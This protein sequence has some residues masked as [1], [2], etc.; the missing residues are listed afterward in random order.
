MF[1]CWVCGCS[2]MSVE[3]LDLK[4]IIDTTLLLTKYSGSYGKTVRI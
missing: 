4:K 3:F 1:G 2:R